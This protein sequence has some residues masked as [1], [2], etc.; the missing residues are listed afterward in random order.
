MPISLHILGGRKLSM[1]IKQFNQ[2]LEGTFYGAF[3]TRQEIHRSVCELIAAG[4]FERHPDLRVVAAEAGIEYAANLER[5]LDSG[6]TSFWKKFSNLSMMPSE[7]FRR[8]VYLTYI[9][10]PLGLNNLRFT[11]SDHFMWSGDYPHQAVGLARLARARSAAT[12]RRSTASTTTR[13]TSSP[14]ANAARLYDIDVDEVSQPSAVIADEVGPL[15]A[16]LT[17][18]A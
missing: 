17:A 7:Y 1:N 18:S 9:N 12:S 16:A 4:V 10:D 5:K 8:N 11:G 2:N 6:Y 14:V 15:G 13:C 3:E